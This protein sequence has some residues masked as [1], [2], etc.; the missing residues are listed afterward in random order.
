MMDNRPDLPGK[1]F[2]TASIFFSLLWVS[3]LGSLVLSQ[4]VTARERISLWVFNWDLLRFKEIHVCWYFLSQILES[5]IKFQKRFGSKYL[6]LNA[7]KLSDSIYSE[8]SNTS[9]V[10][11]QIRILLHDSLYSTKGLLIQTFIE[12]L[13][14]YL[15]QH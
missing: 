10:Q 2:T 12:P 9:M 11:I 13:S 8:D 5:S 1:V 7:H 3:S 15:T 4:G 14:M 6:T